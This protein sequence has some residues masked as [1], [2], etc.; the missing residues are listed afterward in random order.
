LQ[1]EC[2]VAAA[3]REL[4]G[5]ELELRRLAVTATAILSLVAG[6]ATALAAGGATVETFPVEFTLTAAT[7]PNLAPGTEIDGTGTATSITTF[8]TDRN[9]ATM[10]VN[11]THASGTATDQDGNTYVF[12][13]SNEFRVSDAGDPGVFTGLMS[14]HFSLSGPGPATLNNGFVAKIG[15]NF[16]SFDPINS[17][18]DPLVFPAGTAACDPL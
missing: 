3:L 8:R 17:H 10:V 13:Y 11:S 14:D 6:V 1:V 9:G 7:C 18:G 16:S 15:A 4:E 5:K 2:R 12:Q